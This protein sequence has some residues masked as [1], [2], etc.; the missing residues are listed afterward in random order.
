MKYSRRRF[1]ATRDVIFS[2][3]LRKATRGL[4]EI[5]GNDEAQRE[6]KNVRDRERKKKKSI[7]S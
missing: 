1:I 7:P 4:F 5:P 6:K 2:F 3:S